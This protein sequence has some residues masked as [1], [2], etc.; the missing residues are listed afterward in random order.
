MYEIPGNSSKGKK[1]KTCLI[2]CKISV[3]SQSKCPMKFLK[4]VF[5]CLPDKGLQISN[6]FYQLNLKREKKDGY[7]CYMVYSLS[8]A[9][10]YSERD[11]VLQI[12][13]LQTSLIF[14]YVG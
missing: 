13:P 14:G 12:T 4:I 5:K 1:K 6:K 8:W 3:A 2:L 7:V 10:T 11:V 9:S